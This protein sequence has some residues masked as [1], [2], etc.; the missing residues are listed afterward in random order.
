MRQLRS[1]HGL[2][3]T[4]VIFCSAHYQEEE[5]LRLAEACGDPGAFRPASRKTS[6]RPSSRH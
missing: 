3:A 2:A 4:Q 6:W 5:A 1:D